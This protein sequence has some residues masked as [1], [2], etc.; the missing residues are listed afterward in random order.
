[1]EFKKRLAPG[2]LFKH[3]VFA[4]CLAGLLFCWLPVKSQ[5]GNLSLETV[6]DPEVTFLFNTIQKFQSGIS[7]QNAINLRVTAVDVNWDLYV[8]AETDV[9]GL[10]NEVLSYSDYG[11]HPESGLLELRFRNA[12]NTPNIDGFFP[13][14]DISNPAYIIGSPGA[15]PDINCPEMGTN[16]PGNY[17][18]QPQCYEFT[19]D[20]RIQPGF[21]HRPG[22]YTLNVMYVIVE[23][24]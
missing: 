3:S 6:S 4:I 20:M 17:I 14:D 24:L 8:Y 23:D 15:D 11:L 12:A 22:L 13:I 9:P 7:V 21:D 18:D 2:K 16:T 1:M 19:V 10:W 5:D